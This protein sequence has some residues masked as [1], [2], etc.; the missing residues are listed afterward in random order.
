MTKNILNLFCLV[1]GTI[2][3][4]G[5]DTVH[6]SMPSSHDTRE[7]SAATQAPGTASVSEDAFWQGSPNTV[8]NR[9]QYLSVKQLNATHSGD[10]TANAWVNLA[11]ISKRDS[12][13]TPK[14]VNDLIAWRAANPSHP[15]NSLF[16]DNNTLSSLL[17][18]QQP[19]HIAILL[20]LSGPLGRQGQVVRDG[21]LSSYY[22][23]HTKQAIS[24]YNTNSNPDVSVQYQKALSDGADFVIGP[25]TKDQVKNLMNGSISVTTLALNYTDSSS[26]PTNLY[27][28]GL[29]PQDEAVQLADKAKQAG[30]SRALIIA[31]QSDWG[32]KVVKTLSA[33]WQADGGSVQDVLYVTPQTNLTQSVASLL[34]IT[35]PKEGMN[36]VQDK[37][38]PSMRDQ[39]RQDFDVVFLLTTPQTARVVVPLL[40]F[41]YVDNAPVYA[42][43]SVYSGSRSPQRDM[44]LNGVIFCDTPW[45]ILGSEPRAHGS[46][47][48]A[49]GRDSYL[50]S[51]DLPRLTMLPSFPIYGSTGALTLTSDHQ[52]FRRLPW[53]TIHNGQ[54]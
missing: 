18:T 19:H 11:L 52:V 40:K 28:F 45:T 37:N 36:A 38:S 10:A 6:S 32:Q 35:P 47:L 14:L 31:T 13:N 17:T 29:A 44:D 15:G 26:L 30:H 9:L 24:F 46:R 2:F 20:P 48:Y 1:V 22:A 25:L 39:R 8:W 33:R 12:T 42:I 41:Y 21:F 34:H 7:Q 49:V 4:A 43:S 16:P 27:Q 50:L 53:T 23:A 3:V 5:C 54:P 51:R